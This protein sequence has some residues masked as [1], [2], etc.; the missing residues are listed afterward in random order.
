M[1]IIF[2]L[3]IVSPRFSVL[4]VMTLTS[5]KDVLKVRSELLADT[6]L[7]VRNLRAHR[8]ARKL[9]TFLYLDTREDSWLIYMA[10]GFWQVN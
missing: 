5:I 4:S 9:D 6:L 10:P 1:D 7:L 3:H 8:F 2:T